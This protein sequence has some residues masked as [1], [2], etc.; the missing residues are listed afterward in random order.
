MKTEA[1]TITIPLSEYNE[2]KSETAQLKQKYDQLSE[3]LRL[4]KNKK[5]ASSSEKS[6]YDDRQ[7]LFN[8]AEAEARPSE[9]E[10]KLIEIEKHY[11]KRSRL[12]TDKLPDD[13]AVEV[14]DHELP[15]SERICA[16]CGEHLHEM[17]HESRRELVIIPAQT[18]IR[19]HVRHIYSCRSCE[20][21]GT[22][23][24]VVKAQMSEP[25]I[26]GSFASPEAVSHIMSQKF[27]MSIPL[28][29]QEQ[30]LKRSGILLSRQSMSNWIIKASEDWL[31]PIYEQMKAGLLREEVLHADETTLQVLNEPGKKAQSKSYMWLYRTSGDSTSPAVI[32]EYKPDRKSVNPH[33]FLEGFRG[34]V[35]TDGYDGYHKLSAD[36]TIVGCMA[37]ARRKFDEALRSLPEGDRE[38][39]IAAAG[40]RYC[41]RLFALESEYEGMSFEERHKKRQEKSKPLAEEFFSWAA[42]CRAL[43]QSAAGKAAGY[44]LSQR[45]YLLNYLLD[46]RL[47]ISNNRA[48]RSIKPF[49]IGRKNFMFANTPRGA[50]ASAVMYS[51]IETAKENDISPYKY[52]MYIFENAPGCDISDEQTVQRF[53]PAA[54]KEAIASGLGV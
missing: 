43:P 3:Q 5:Y 17:G 31:E 34:Y 12:I 23:V 27:V 19:E 29:R 36:I 53:M 14:I 2:M 40:K 21:H 37:H 38:G 30:E 8:E 25:V 4:L 39:S 28:Y 48:E 44:V 50:K 15:E 13:I 6:E 20:K 45:K 46:G 54:V 33:K 11:R 10:P 47:E 35:H 7:L 42:E 1:E 51:I 32:Y 22:R 9:A 24:P 52:L 26:K 18:K 49:V 41:D 16:E